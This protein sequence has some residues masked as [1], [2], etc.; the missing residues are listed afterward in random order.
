MKLNKIKCRFSYLKSGSFEFP[1]TIS[2]P[3]DYF[4]NEL[5]FMSFFLINDWFYHRFGIYDIR[6]NVTG[7]PDIFAS[8]IGSGDD[9]GIEVEYDASNFSRHGHSPNHT[10]LIISFIR[11]SQTR[12][13][14]NVP[15]WSVYRYEAI[16]GRRIFTYTLDE[17]IDYKDDR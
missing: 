16:E 5:E 10:D 12:K 3:F 14:K 6:R 11:T 8:I 15:I 17:D 13:I 9:I 4:K 7:S 2:S 1:E